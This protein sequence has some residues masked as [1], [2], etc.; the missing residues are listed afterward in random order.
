MGLLLSVDTVLLGTTGLIIVM[1]SGL[2][3]YQRG[4]SFGFSQK[5]SPGFNIVSKGKTLFNY[6]ISLYISINKP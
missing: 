1:N 2:G 5:M 4:P 3:E 6:M